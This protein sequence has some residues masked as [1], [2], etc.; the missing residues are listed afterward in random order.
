MGSEHHRGIHLTPKTPL[1]P[2][3][4]DKRVPSPFVCEQFPMNPTFTITINKSQ[5]QSIKSKGSGFIDQG[6]LHSW[7][8]LR[9]SI[10]GAPRRYVTPGEVE[11]I[12]N[13]SSTFSQIG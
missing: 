2:K 10:R 3:A 1:I 11:K 13:K 8:T 12:E 7:P 5:G 6:M 9:G 4:D